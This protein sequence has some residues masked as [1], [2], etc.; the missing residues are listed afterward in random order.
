MA[1]NCEIQEARND[2]GQLC[3][4]EGEECKVGIAT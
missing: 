1:N 2:D 4:H 3:N